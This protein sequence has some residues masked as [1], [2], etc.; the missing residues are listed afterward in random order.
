MTYL[1]TISYLEENFYTTDFINNHTRPEMVEI[2]NK[3]YSGNKSIKFKR[4][5]C[6]ERQIEHIR[7]YLKLHNIK[8]KGE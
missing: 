7:H 3:L 5:M 6:K 8:C 2:L 1:E 4:R